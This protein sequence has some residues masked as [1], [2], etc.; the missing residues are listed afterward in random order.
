MF[1]KTDGGRVRR[2]EVQS[3]SCGRSASLAVLSLAP[4]SLCTADGEAVR[5]EDNRFTVRYNFAVRKNCIKAPFMCSARSAF[6]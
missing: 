5:K 6:L 4:L 1:Y 3:V 2:T